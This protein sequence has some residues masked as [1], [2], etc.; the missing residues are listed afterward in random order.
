MRLSTFVLLLPA[1]LCS[2]LVSAEPGDT[3]ILAR[4]D[5]CLTELCG[6]DFSSTP[7]TRDA[8]SPVLNSRINLSN[9]E[10][11]RRGMAPA[12]PTRRS[13]FP[14]YI[15]A[16][17]S[18]QFTG[19]AKRTD[20]SPIP[21]TCRRGRIIVTNTNTNGVI[22]Y[23]SKNSLSGAQLRY[24][25]N[26]EDAL[27]VKFDFP[28]GA[29]SSG[30]LDFAQENSD[31]TGFPLVGAIQGRD[32]TSSDISAGSFHYLY[33]G[34]TNASPARS[35]PQSGPNSYSTV[36]NRDREFESAIW[37]YNSVS[38]AISV[39]WT[40]SDGSLPT[41]QIW[42]QGTAIYLGGDKDAFLTRYPSPVTPLAFSF[43]EIF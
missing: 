43:E 4:D 23:I 39:Q 26:Q 7:V 5:G 30:D 31:I 3:S 37:A 32:D 24:Q 2:L 17:F 20:T 21:T 16:L 13:K 1:V 38:K 9:A 41:T 14:L 29:L 25:P 28:V 11:L 40:N 36:T 33:L 6:S 15:F 18:E 12:P 35:T 27:I 19:T 42:T 34:G 10:R 22:G 8:S